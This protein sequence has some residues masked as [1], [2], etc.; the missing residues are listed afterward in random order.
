MN[1][2]VDN[3]LMNCCWHWHRKIYSIYEISEDCTYDC[4]VISALLF[5][6]RFQSITSFCYSKSDMEMEHFLFTTF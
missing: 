6:L 5:T 1:N 3:I 4:K 2:V